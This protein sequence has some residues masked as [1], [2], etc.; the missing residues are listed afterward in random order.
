MDEKSERKISSKKQWRESEEER[1]E[2]ERKKDEFKIDCYTSVHTHRDSIH[3]WTKKSTN[4]STSLPLASRH[5][6]IDYRFIYLESMYNNLSI[7]L[8]ILLCGY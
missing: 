7:Y 5:T 3:F 2:K 4:G 8:S 1:E 6:Q